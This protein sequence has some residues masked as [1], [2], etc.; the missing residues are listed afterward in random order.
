MIHCIFQ[1]AIIVKA[2]INAFRKPVP[3][4]NQF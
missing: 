4:E 2:Y 3:V 1:H